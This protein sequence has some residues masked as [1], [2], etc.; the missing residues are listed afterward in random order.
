MDLDTNSHS[1]AELHAE[2]DRLFPHGFAGPDVVQE[3]APGGWATSPLVAVFHP[4]VD[5]LYEE[6]LAMHRNLESLRRPDDH[7]PGSPEPEPSREEIAA[8]YRAR[9]IEPEAE[10]RVLV[11]QCLWDIFSDSHEIVAVED[12]RVL[13]LGSFR[14]A[15]GILADIANRQTGTTQYDYM[16]FYLGTSWVAQR[17]D[18]TP[19][20]AMIFRRLRRRELDWIYH[21]PRLYAVDL[22]PLKEALD[23]EQQRAPEWLNYSPSE[24]LAREEEQKRRDQELAELRESLDAG[25]REAVA[26]ALHAPPPATV[27]AYQGVYGHFPRGWPPEA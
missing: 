21:F 26:E 13:D 25:Y 5:Q 22:R 1:D 24:A 2:F 7:R 8:E 20:Y 23:Q 3:L 14:C 18:L 15:G 10:V 19:V 17:A 27:R 4:S 9:P 6:A 11:G 16:D 12:G